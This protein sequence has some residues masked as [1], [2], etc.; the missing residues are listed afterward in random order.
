[1]GEPIAEV[2]YL[3]GICGHD[4][5]DWE[6]VLIDASKRLVV[7]V[8]AL[9]G[10]V[11]VVQSD[12]ADL[13]VG[14][15]QFDGSAWRKSNLLFGYN[16]KWAE[17]MGG[18]ATGTEWVKNSAVVPAGEIWVLQALSIRNETRAPGI[19]YLFAYPI[20]GL[21]VCLNYASSLALHE[22]LLIGGTFAIHAGG[23][24]RVWMGGC[25]ALDVIEGG[26]I[27]YKMKLDM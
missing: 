27:G 14:Q 24:V 10:E 20:A 3:A 17:N 6:K 1:M 5:T 25:Q 4:G 13:L 23:Y 12:P 19:T 26:T 21:P 2:G 15:H 7:A 9:S 22:P 8:A 16:D 18:D 11:E